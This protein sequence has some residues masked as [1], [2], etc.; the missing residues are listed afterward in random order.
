MKVITITITQ[1]RNDSSLRVENL[2]PDKSLKPT[3]MP[4]TPFAEKSKLAPRYGGLVPPFGF[5][6]AGKYKNVIKNLR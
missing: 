6:N 2:R 4:V 1:K 5:R 3:E